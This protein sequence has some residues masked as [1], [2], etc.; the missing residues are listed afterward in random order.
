[1]KLGAVCA[2]ESDE[3]ELGHSASTA[4]WDPDRPLQP[5]LRILRVRHSEHKSTPLLPEPDESNSFP[6]FLASLSTVLWG[7]RL[8]DTRGGLTMTADVTSV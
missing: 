4:V 1:M 7:H 3:G 6:V 2:A 8:G 5:S